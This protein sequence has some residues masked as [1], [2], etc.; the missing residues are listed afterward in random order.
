MRKTQPQPQTKPKPTAMATKD[1]EVRAKSIAAIESERQYQLRRWGVRQADGTFVEK[2]KTFDAF[3][4]L[5]IHYSRQAVSAWVK[6]PSDGVPLD[7]LR[8]IGACA[9]A[10]LQ[11]TQL[12]AWRPE[13]YRTTMTFGTCSVAPGATLPTFLFKIYRMIH[14]KTESEFSVSAGWFE[15]ILWHILACFDLLDASPR[16]IPESILITNARDGKPA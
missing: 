15:S 2:Q 11:Q 1:P 13:N 5:L 14:A 7:E 3:M 9:L 10:A 8:K 12:E 6:N 16:V 4:C